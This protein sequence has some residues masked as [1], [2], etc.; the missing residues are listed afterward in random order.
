[1]DKIDFVVPWVDNSDPHWQ[2][3]LKKHQ[4]DQSLFS[5]ASDKRYRDWGLFKYWFR[6]V[7]KYAPWVN[8]VHLVTFGHYPEWLDLEH[9]K[10]NFVTHEDYMPKQSLPVFSAHPIEMHLHKIQGLAEHFVYFNDDLFLINK[11]SS[12]DFFT[13]GL[14]N[15]SAVLTAYDGVGFSKI[16]LNNIALINKYY[17][18][19][20]AIKRNP[21]KW[22]S[23]KY[24]KELLRNFLLFPWN[25]YTGFYDYHLTNSYVKSTFED[26]WSKEAELLMKVTSNKFRNLNEDVSQNVFRFWQ[27]ASNQFNPINKHKLGDFV[28][29]GQI[30]N[31]TALKIFE[32]SKKPLI[33]LND[34]DPEDLEVLI[35]ELNAVF[36]SK[37]PEKSSFEL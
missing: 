22:F 18:K 3:E 34:H 4:S 7:E 1:M 28:S 10:L 29:L 20:T 9:P 36:E 14:P 19:R 31:N 11:S 25:N 6:G 15:D 8:K 12:S 2:L 13:N 17:S 35:D 33:C 27:L 32:N 5:D 16:Q 21:S 23:L 26:V 30:S 24:G 37:F